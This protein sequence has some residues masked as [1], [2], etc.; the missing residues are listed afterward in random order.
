VDLTITNPRVCATGELTRLLAQAASPEVAVVIDLDAFERRRLAFERP[1]LLVLDALAHSRA[2]VVL[3]SS[4]D[5]QPPLAR[6]WIVGRGAVAAVR[7][8]IPGVAVIAVSDDPVVFDEL[9][10]RDRGLSLVGN[11]RGTGNV[12]ATGEL[13]MRA[14]LWWIVRARGSGAEKPRSGPRE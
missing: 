1:L 2:R 12:V 3:A 9:A 14:A 5:L 8:R 4:R 13:A 6:C 10:E 7:A 11:I